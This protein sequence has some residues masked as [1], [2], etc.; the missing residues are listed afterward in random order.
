MKLEWPDIIEK[1]KRELPQ[2][3]SG[4]DVQLEAKQA[5]DQ[6]TEKEKKSRIRSFVF[7]KRIMPAKPAWFD[8]DTQN[9]TLGLSL[10]AAICFAGTFWV[11]IAAGL[12]NNQILSK[13]L[14][15]Q[16]QKTYTYQVDLA[17]SNQTLTVKLNLTSSNSLTSTQLKI[18]NLVTELD[19][20]FAAAKQDFDQ[21][22]KTIDQFKLAKHIINHRKD[23]IWS[24]KTGPKIS[25]VGFTIKPLN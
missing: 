6:P 11:A 5:A 4:Q 17:Q 24:M 21:M 13:Q 25:I 18:N 20:D 10:G 2:T 19:Q 3:I 23:A 16:N 22:S 1:I 12:Y 7:K 9:L 15:L 8:E 14:D